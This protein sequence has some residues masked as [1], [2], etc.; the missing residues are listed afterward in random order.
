MSYVID[1]WN[2]SLGKEEQEAVAN[3]IKSRK[4]A[5]GSITE[6]FEE[7]VAK[8]LNVPYALAVPNG[9][10]ALT[11]AYMGLGI[12]LGDEIIMPNRTFVATAHAGVILGAR[13]KA[14]DVKDNQTINEE[15]LEI[16]I[17]CK[18]KVI[19]PVHLN[20]V[21]SNMDRILEIAKKHNIEIV[22]DACQAFGSKDSKGRNLGSFGRFGCFSL[23]LA[24]ILTTGQGG[25]V[26]MK[27]KND[28][29][30]LRRIR[31]Q[32]VFDVRSENSY[33]IKAYN[34]KFNDMQASVGLVQLSK[35]EE[36]MKASINNYK[37][38][39]EKLKGVKILKSN[40]ENGEVPMRVLIFA[41]DNLALREYLLSKGIKTSL[42]SPSLNHCPHLNIKEEFP[43]SEVFNNELL[44]L[45]SGP[46]LE[47]EKI[48]IVCNE[49]NKWVE[50]NA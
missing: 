22:E 9:T 32:G 8:F 45:P 38:Y 49:V 5:Q 14:I 10:Q 1:W 6:E 28:Y 48:D 35:I 43:V 2:I 29:D 50:E 11:L 24:K 26:V 39:E 7:K 25:I 42:E 13:I 41:K 30:R 21:A 34:F 19:V 20:G 40:I 47:L 3:A 37:R 31:N 33:E 27:D 44:I 4:I 16:A 36:K 46:N 15:L 12:E 18:T 17:T 23:G